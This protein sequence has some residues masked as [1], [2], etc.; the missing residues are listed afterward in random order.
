MS[1]LYKQNGSKNWWIGWRDGG[2]QFLVSTKT[3]DKSAAL[4]KLHEQEHL[5]QM[6][7]DGRLTEQFIEAISGK[8]LPTVSLATAA[9]DWLAEARA[10]TAPATVEKYEHVASDFLKFMRATEAAPLWREVQTEHVR[11]FLTEQRTRISARTANVYRKILSGFFI[12]GLK[13]EP[14]LLKSN[15]VL[16][17]KAFKAARGEVMERRALTISELQL[18]Y[19]KAPNDFWRY[20]VLAGFYTGLRLGDLV[21]MK[22]G[23]VDFAANIIRVTTIKTGRPAQ[24]PMAAPL[25]ALL[26]KLQP[27]RKTKPSEFLWPAQADLY[28]RQ[29]ARTFS[30]E[31]YDEVLTPAGLA[32]ARNHKPKKNGEKRETGVSFHCLRHSFVS[33]LKIT[34]SNNAV[35]KELVGHSS[36]SV[37]DVYTH[38]PIETLATAVAQ[39]P[40]V[41]Q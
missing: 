22:W 10:T 8:S 33:F 25:R 9:K 12:R 27:S 24:I 18:I 7:L 26:E 17:I 19:S 36:D 41:T 37:N 34:G 28:Q 31:F 6:R 29:R 16:P 5:M 15:P 30:N 13:N 35:A 21:T 14:P 40:E 2:R 32:A 1:W 3:A 38:I 23:S 11:Q 39:L 4:K 20:M